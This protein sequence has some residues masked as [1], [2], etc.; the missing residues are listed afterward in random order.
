[1]VIHDF[2]FFSTVKI[3]VGHCAINKGNN[4]ERVLKT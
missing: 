2:P 3:I 1:M 4:G